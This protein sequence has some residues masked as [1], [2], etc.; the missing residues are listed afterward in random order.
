MKPESKQSLK[1][2]A[3]SIGAVLVAIATAVGGVTTLLDSREKSRQAETNRV[4]SDEAV[5][6]E[7]SKQFEEYADDVDKELDDIHDEQDQ[8]EQ[9]LVELQIRVGVLERLGPDDD[10]VRA[11]LAEEIYDSAVEYGQPVTEL[12]AQ[13]PAAPWEGIDAEAEDVAEG[14]TK[15]KTRKTRT[16]AFPAPKASGEFLEKIQRKAW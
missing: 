8:C 5:Y 7:L 16:P 6:T 3:P 13:D 4:E 15:K 11:A 1:S 14:W 9:D 10:L 12:P 2:H